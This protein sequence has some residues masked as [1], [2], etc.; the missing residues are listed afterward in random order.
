MAHT[1]EPTPRS[2]RRVRRRRALAVV[3]AGLVV[4]LGA[5]GTALAAGA[6]PGV[7]GTPCSASAR[8]C[9]DLGS[10]QAWLMNGGSVTYGPVD[11]AT[12]GHGTETPTGDFAVYDK[13]R[14]H[15]SAEFDGAPMPWS[16]FFAPGGVAFHQG[17][18]DS[19]SAGCVKMRNQDA[20]VFFG[21]LRQGDRVEVR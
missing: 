6:D 21:K 14:E 5:A 13:D 19:G 7:A 3:T 20:T 11:V 12:G 18:R 10:Q 17:D 16:V 9:V 8:A 1:N 2:T 4:G 15:Y